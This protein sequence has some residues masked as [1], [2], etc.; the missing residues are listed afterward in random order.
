MGRLK[1]TQDYRGKI[2]V[3]N[4]APRICGRIARMLVQGGYYCT[5]VDSAHEA[6]A[7][8]EL[9]YFDTTLYAHEFSPDHAKPG[10]P[11]GIR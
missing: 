11:F 6:N 4:D 10:L 7:L 5:F 1:K 8:L 2:L 3:I 9:E